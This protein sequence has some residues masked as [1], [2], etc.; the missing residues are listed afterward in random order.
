MSLTND[1]PAEKAVLGAVLLRP[2]CLDDLAYLEPRDFFQK[3]NELIYS[4]MRYFYDQDRPVDITTV[5]EH[6]HRKNRLQDIGGISYLT[7]L[8]ESCPNA[9]NVR[10]YADAVRSNAIRR[11]GAQKGQQIIDL[12]R[13]DF[14]SDEEYFSA[15]DE[16]VDDLR[17]QVH[18]QMRSFREMR[19]AYMQHTRSKAEKLRTGYYKQYDEWAQLWRGWLFV[20]AGRPGVGKTADALQTAV[21]VAEYNPDAGVILIFS[22]EM[23]ELELTD[24]MVS[25]I[26]QINYRRLINKG[27]E[28]GFTQNELERI[29]KAYEKLERLPIFIQDKAGVTID[30]VRATARRFKKKYGKIAMIIVDYLQIMHIPQQKNESRSQAIGRVTST[31]KRIARSMNCVFMMLSQMTRASEDRDEPKLSDLKESGSIEQ[32]ADVVHFLWDTGEMEKSAK[33][34]QSIYAKGRNVGTRKFRLAFEWWIQ[35]FV[36]LEPKEAASGERKKAYRK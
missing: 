22:Q 32:D 33:V 1:L 16:I 30:E 4:V 26:G 11:R 3:R 7:E 35:R 8:A 19:G 36:E 31:A 28:E 13:E 15:I 27:G 25:M 18:A 24:R 29:E 14:D 2:E 12:S 5:A 34:I 10:Y 6:F 23:T 21:G 17:P 20:K 9:A